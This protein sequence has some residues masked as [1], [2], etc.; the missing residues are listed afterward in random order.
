MKGAL[1]E[2]GEE[3]RR[4]INN[5]LSRLLQ[6]K[7][8]D[9]ILAPIETST[10]LVT[11]GFVTNPEKTHI[12]DALAPVIPGVAMATVVSQI[13]HEKPVEKRL[14]VILKPCDARA[15]VE[16][17]KFQ[18]VNLEN[19]YLIGVDCYGTYPVIKY[20]EILEKGDL[21]VENVFE[22]L[23][24]GGE[25]EFRDSCKVC[26]NPVPIYSDLCIGYIG[27]EKGKLFIEARTEKGE[28]FLRKL[29][30]KLLELKERN[31]AVAEIL[32]ERE[33]KREKYF[34]EAEK[35]LNGMEGINSF[36]EDCIACH[37]CME[38][39][40]ICFCKECFFD[41]D[42]YSYVNQNYLEWNPLEGTVPMLQAKVQFHVGRAVH[43]ASS[44]VHCGLCEQACPQD[45]ALYKLFGL[46]ARNIQ[47]IFNY[48]PGRSVEEKPPVQEFKEEELKEFIG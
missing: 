27:I 4:T 21:P 20:K 16:L 42:R 18:Q 11:P 12:I 28:E 33:T 47:R 10:G 29:G 14:G 48:T 7:M 13:T 23:N 39:C 41:S 26:L 30:F 24:K 35:E 6:E 3:T 46:I 45:I 5:F 17:V 44:C 19:I 1:F 40:P 36:F 43:M 2:T 38:V 15:L 37:N 9:A 22:A 25:T 8:V 34:G 32:R 31:R